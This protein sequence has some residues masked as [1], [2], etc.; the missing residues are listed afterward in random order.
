MSVDEALARALAD[1]PVRTIPEVLALMARI[2]A[3]LPQDDGIACFNRLYRRT[4]ENVLA[5]IERGAF[6]DPSAIARLDVVFANL[7]FG[8]VYECLVTP[9]VAPRAWLPLVEARRSRDVAPIQFALA[10]M[11]AHINRDLAPS[12]VETFRG[13]RAFPSRDSDQRE[14]YERVDDILAV[15]ADEVKAWFEGEVLAAIDRGLGR[16]DDVIA[17]FSIKKARE[18]AW[19]WGETLH[20][21][22]PHPT[23]ADHAL[24]ALDR[25][26]GLATRALLLSMPNV[27]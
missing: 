12:L 9:A 26:T 19:T 3:L 21:L 2:D 16:V 5:A 10:G 24:L 17:L 20:A 11:N 8:G 1:A 22:D 13:A 4:T 7:Y 14:D 6:A 15:T 25:S 18:A 27:E 23:L